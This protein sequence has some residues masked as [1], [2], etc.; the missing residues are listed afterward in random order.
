M[1]STPPITQH[2]IFISGEAGYHTY[3]IPALIVTQAGT[4]LAF[5]EGRREGRGDAGAIDI[6]LKRSTDGGLTWSAAQ[7]VWRDGDNTCGNP[8]PVI[9]QADGTIWL[10]L[11][12]NLGTD[13]ES[14]IVD[15]SS[16]DTR[17]VFITHS[18]DDGLT[19]ATPSEITAQVKPP[20]W[21]W[22][23]TGPGVGIQ[24]QHRPYQGRLVIPCDHKVNG[25]VRRYHAHVIY[26]DD[27]GQSWQLGGVAEDGTNECQV[28]ERGDGSLL[29]N[30]RR[31]EKV[32]DPYRYVAISQDGG[33]SWLPNRADTTLIDP[34]CQGSIIRHQP[35]DG[36]AVTL[37]SNAAHPSQRTAM[38]IRA[39][40]DDGE[41]WPIAKVIHAGPTAYSGLTALPDGRLACLYEGGE[42]NPYETLTL[43]TFSLDWLLE[44]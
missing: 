12:W 39:S 4:V 10:P 15:G 13:R 11:T 27:H 43:A 8:C 19:W 21:S 40:F 18:R 6:L 16:Q 2:P 24:L 14:Q 20:H 38:T 35:A 42:A 36:P 44:S 31:S 22:Y 41:S 28:I 23:A 1:S 17:R 25:D 26:S 5:C 29:L 32:S 9:D 30:M 7:I 33:L 3:R 34:R 37:F